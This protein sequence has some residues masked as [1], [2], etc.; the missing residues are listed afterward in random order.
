MYKVRFHLARGENFRKWQVLHNGKREYYDP[1]SVSLVM[2]GCRL[3]NNPR[4]ARII[5]DGAEKSVCAW[6][7][8]SSVGVVDPQPP[9]ESQVLYNPRVT[10]NW[11]DGNGKNLDG[12]SVPRL[13]T[14]GRRIFMG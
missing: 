10:P 6:V 7:S 8:C 5:N 3:H 1:K 11:C 2:E 9:G 14:S 13:S 4:V 12:M